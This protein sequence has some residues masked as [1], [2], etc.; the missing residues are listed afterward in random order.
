WRLL[1]G[2][3]RRRGH[4]LHLAAPAGRLATRAARGRVRVAP[5]PHEP[6]RPAPAVARLCRWPRVARAPLRGIRARA[7][8]RAGR[9]TGRAGGG[10]RGGRGSARRAAA[11]SERA[12]RVDRGAF[13]ALD[14]LLSVEELTGFA[15]SNRTRD[16]DTGAGDHEV[17]LVAERFPARGDPLVELA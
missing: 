12:S 17:V 5:V 1:R 4:R 2:R 13:V 8:D 6:R 11:G 15:L 3:P 9:E 7:G 10:G 14:A 16:R